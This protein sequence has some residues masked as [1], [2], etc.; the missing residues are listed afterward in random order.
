MIGVKSW[1]SYF[2]SVDVVSDY[3]MAEREG[4]IKQKKL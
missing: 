3:F 1:D 2:N 4:I